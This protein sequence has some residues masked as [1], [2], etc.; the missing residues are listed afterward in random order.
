MNSG[1]RY[2]TASTGETGKQKIKEKRGNS[3]GKRFCGGAFRG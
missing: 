1:P 2:A 3:S